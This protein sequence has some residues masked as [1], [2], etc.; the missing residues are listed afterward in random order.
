MANFTIDNFRSEIRT[1]G[2]SRSNR[3]EVILPSLNIP[4][5]DDIIKLSSLFCESTAL[6]PIAVSTRQTKIQGPIYQR[7]TSVEYGGNIPLT[8]FVDRDMNIRALFEIWLSSVIKPGSFE[9]GY[10]NDYA[11]PIELIQLDEQEVGVYKMTLIDAF[12]VAIAQQ[13]IN[14]S[15]QGFH[16]L[17]VTFAYRYWNSSY[18][19]NT[20]GETP[21]IL[22][23]RQSL[24]SF[25]VE[26]DQPMEF[27]QPTNRTFAET[28]AG[29]VTG[30][31][32]SK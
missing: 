29:A 5:W 20:Y 10:F 4:G 15:L 19:N 27:N 24:A 32:K 16:R 26:Q 9:V 7:G 8:F 23:P 1:R 14:N 3:F 28:P 12:P 25:K 11:K 17:T 18:I 13:E 2:L 21:S 31:A 6:A 30:V 22:G